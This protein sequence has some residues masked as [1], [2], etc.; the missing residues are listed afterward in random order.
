MTQNPVALT[1]VRWRTVSEGGR[2]SPPPGPLYPTAAR[3][4]NDTE[5]FSAVLRLLKPISNGDRLEHEAELQ[6]LAPDLMPDIAS[7]L[8]PGSR[9]VIKEGRREVADC[10]V[11]AVTVREVS[12]LGVAH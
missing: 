6:L 2:D 3:F 12:P 5:V 7:K 4:D 9:L 1:R 8:V 10:E 11:V